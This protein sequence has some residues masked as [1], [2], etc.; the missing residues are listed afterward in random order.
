MVRTG[1]ICND[2]KNSAPHFK[3]EYIEC[4]SEQIKVD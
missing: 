2:L 4:L 1:Y 3:F